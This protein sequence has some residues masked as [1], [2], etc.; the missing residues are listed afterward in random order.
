MSFCS[1]RG[2]Y[3][4]YREKLLRRL[5]RAFV[6]IKSPWNSLSCVLIRS[7]LAIPWSI[8]VWAF[9][10]HPPLPTP[11]LFTAPI[12]RSLPLF[13]SS[14]TCPLNFPQSPV[15]HQSPHR[16]FLFPVLKVKIWPL[17]HMCDVKKRRWPKQLRSA[18][19]VMN[20]SFPCNCDACVCNAVVHKLLS[21][22]RIW[23]VWWW[24]VESIQRFLKVGQACPLGPGPQI[25]K[26]FS[27]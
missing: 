18:L 21:V 12:S 2:K 25:F 4:H 14:L 19:P 24:L 8:L 23:I 27:I 20:H 11:P 9:P 10:C 26:N 3:Q 5:F 6:C 17:V 1:W 13:L 16:G 22:C 7:L 15:P